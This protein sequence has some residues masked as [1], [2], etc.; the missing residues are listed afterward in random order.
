MDF[1][2]MGPLEII[3]ILV[4]GLIALGPAKLPQL[5]RNLAK[6]VRAFRK[7]TDE[8]TTMVTKELEDEEIEEKRPSI[9]KEKERDTTEKMAENEA[10]KSKS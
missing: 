5:A 6:A 9:L 7:A 10:G 1:F 8:L 3:L 4:V 2:G